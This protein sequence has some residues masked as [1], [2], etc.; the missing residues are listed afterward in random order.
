MCEVKRTPLFYVIYDVG[1]LAAHIQNIALGPYLAGSVFGE[2]SADARADSFGS[3]AHGLVG[4]SC[5]L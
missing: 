2:A 4:R 3:R 5:R 1:V